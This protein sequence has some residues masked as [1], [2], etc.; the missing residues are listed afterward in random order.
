MINDALY[1]TKK[2]EKFMRGSRRLGAEGGGEEFGISA[3]ETIKK[4]RKSMAAREKTTY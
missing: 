1:N 2:R 4:K 3:Y